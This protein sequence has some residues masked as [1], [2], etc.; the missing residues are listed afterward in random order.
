MHS[1]PLGR[2]RHQVQ[3][4]IGSEAAPKSHSDIRTCDPLLKAERG[5]TETEGT[6]SVTNAG[7]T[8]T[9]VIGAQSNQI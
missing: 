6:A 1:R 2:G 4:K 5:N 3:D 7:S 9:V 8:D